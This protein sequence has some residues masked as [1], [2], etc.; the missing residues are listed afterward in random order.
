MKDSRYE[1]DPGSDALDNGRVP[2]IK[3]NQISEKLVIGMLVGLFV[4]IM[5]FLILKLIGVISPMVMRICIYPVLA[6][7][8]IA[9]LVV[10]SRNNRIL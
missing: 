2:D 8:I 3:E 6:L 4:W 5:I 9:Y 10:K 1:Y 7:I